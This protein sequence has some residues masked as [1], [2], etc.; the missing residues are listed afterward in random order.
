LGEFAVCDLDGTI[1]KQ[2]V[3]V[4]LLDRFAPKKYEYMEELYHSG[5]WSLKRTSLE[6]FRLLRETREVL[7]AYVKEN[8]E[9]DPDFPRFVELC[10]G[11]GIG[12]AVASEGLDFYIEALLDMMGLKGLEYY[13]N[14]AAFGERVLEDV[15]FPNWNPDCGECGTCKVSIIKKYQAWGNKVTFVGEGRTDRHAAHF[16]DRV[17]AKGLLL[18]YCRE[19]GIEC[20]EYDGF[21]EVI[22]KMGLVDGSA[23]A[24]CM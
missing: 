5:E 10:Q 23:R 8:A 19:R 15:F 18:G 16:A 11:K 6:E 20:E 4:L 22:Q 1:T 2:D 9:F 12:V 13:G 3:S 17:F 21:K 7:T 24:D 14:L